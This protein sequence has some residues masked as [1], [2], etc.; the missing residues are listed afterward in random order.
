MKPNEHFV[1]ADAFS[2][3]EIEHL[4]CSDVHEVTSARMNQV[5]RCFLQQQR[6]SNG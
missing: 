5:R 6:V 1:K 3:G 2:S 4:W